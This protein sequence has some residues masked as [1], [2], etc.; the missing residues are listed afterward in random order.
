MPKADQIAIVAGSF[1]RKHVENMVESAIV[2]ASENDLVITEQVWVFGSMEKPLAL[3]SLLR[4]PAISGAIA[5]GIIENGQTA[6][7][8]VMA[9][10]VFKAILDLQLE[11]MKPIGVGI[12][13]P[14]ISRE[15]IQERLVPYAQNSVLA[16]RSA[17]E[18]VGKF[19]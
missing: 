13:G 1:H 10:A 2:T 4:K 17:L 15:E 14:E 12:L 19:C 18:N 6:H 5:L 9:E 8:R 7:G 16:V 11:L 3:K